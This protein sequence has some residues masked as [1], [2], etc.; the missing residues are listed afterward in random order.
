M[1]ERKRWVAP[2]LPKTEQGTM[3]ST[4]T[5]S[6]IRLSGK[7]VGVLAK[8][9]TYVQDPQRLVFGTR[10]VLGDAS[11]SGIYLQDS[12]IPDQSMVTSLDSEIEELQKELG[13]TM[14]PLQPRIKS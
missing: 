5:I 6:D 1:I 10:V 14:D 4:N 7:V 2:V 13:I 11:R 3:I 12:S 8:A 9:D